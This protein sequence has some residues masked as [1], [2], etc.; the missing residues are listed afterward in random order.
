MIVFSPSDLLAILP[1]LLVMTAGC[2]VLLLASYLHDSARRY[3]V[4][5][6][7]AGSGGSQENVG[8]TET[9]AYLVDHKT[10]RVWEL[11]GGL[12]KP[13]LYL[14]CK[15]VSQNLKETEHG[16]EVEPGAPKTQP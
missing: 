1:E 15:K 7:A 9:A 11:D 10:G 6:A 16:C 4:V 12:E 2:L 5:L 14:S 8:S 13:L 3:D